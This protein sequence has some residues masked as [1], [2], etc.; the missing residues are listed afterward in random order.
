MIDYGQDFRFVE[1]TL[2]KDE[3]TGQNKFFKS[4]VEALN[5]FSQVN[6]HRYEFLQAYTV[7]RPNKRLR[8]HYVLKRPKN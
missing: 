8:Y 7:T 6:T 5:L 2:I 3:N 1:E 4:M